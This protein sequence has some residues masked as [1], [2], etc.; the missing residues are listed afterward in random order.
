MF[1]SLH[2]LKLHKHDN[3]H[4]VC[5]CKCS[6]FIVIS[7]VV[8]YTSKRLDVDVNLLTLVEK[9]HDIKQRYEIDTQIFDDKRVD[10]HDETN[11]K[12]DEMLHSLAKY[13]IDDSND[14]KHDDVDSTQSIE[15]KCYKTL[16]DDYLLQVERYNDACEKMLHVDEKYSK[17]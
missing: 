5:L 15:S 7:N 10:N 8:F 14:D 13:H 16:F 11:K 17:G 1:V 12:M 4:Q 2:L 9:Y 6:N 3:H